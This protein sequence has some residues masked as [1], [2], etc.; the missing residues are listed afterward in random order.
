MV[1][2]KSG[3]PVG[4]PSSFSQSIADEIC[5]RLANGESLR[6]ICGR[7]D[8]PSQATVFVWLAKDPAFQEQYAR[9]RTTQ[10]D[11]LF[12]QILSIADTPLIGVKTVTKGTTVETTEGDMI[13]HRRLQIDARKWL[14]GK[15]APKKYG[16]KS[17]LEVSGPNGGPV[18]TVVA[19]MTAQEAAEA[20]AG[21]LNADE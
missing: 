11:V 8:M 12:D 1:Q 7:E 6:A 15:L 9:A 5:E 17:S 16:E 14:A 19:T 4:R 3:K 20:Y 21:T 10:A 18:Q 13:E 2:P